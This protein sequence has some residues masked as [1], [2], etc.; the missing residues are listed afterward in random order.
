MP[1]CPHCMRIGLLMA[2]AGV[3]F[4]TYMIDGQDKPA[5]FLEAF[6]EGT[7]PVG[8][9][10]YCPPRHPTHFKPSFIELHGIL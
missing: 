5:W 1:Y 3:P 8:P 4:E 7:T 10:E 9:G 6:P 2:E